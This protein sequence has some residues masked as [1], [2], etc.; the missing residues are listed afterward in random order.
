MKQALQLC[1]NYEPPFL[2]VAYQYSTT[3]CALGYRV[4]TVYLKGEESESVIKHSNSE[5]VIFLKN[6]SKD[7]R[8]LKRKQI[9]QL[10]NIC[11]TNNFDFVVA[12]RFKAI[13][14]ST[15]IPTI[16]VIGV[17]HCFGDYKR[18]SRR[19]YIY[20]NK[21]RISLIGVSNAIRDDIRNSLPRLEKDR[22]NTLYNR[23]DLETLEKMQIDKETARE[24]LGLPK[25]KYIFSNVGRLHP[26]KDQT[27][28]IKAFEQIHSELPDSILVIL[29]KGELE[30]DLKN[31][32]N[33]LSLKKKVFF[34]GMVKNA[35]HYFKAFD[36]FIL[37][38]DREP[39]GMVLLEA[40][41]AG[42][43]I[44][45]TDC[46]GAP[47]VTGET[48]LKF[49]FGSYTELSEAMKKLYNMTETE[50]ND[51][52]AKMKERIC[53]HFTDATSTDSFRK[54]INTLKICREDND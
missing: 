7:I 13:Y 47:E 2:D 46:G 31:L 6:S 9:K 27:T 12:H 33:T 17:H 37:S 23:I 19:W 34:L 40:M 10:K 30:E 21:K 51:M 41:T 52:H 32:V 26:D 24:Q 22:I 25:D 45:I 49:P 48:A 53:D 28:L 1:H 39:F 5:E 29:G 14:I 3:L 36:S 15:H 43:P 50:I 4:T 20:L 11:I 35:S 44:A 38:S 8:G 54:I 42:L 16:P 18:L